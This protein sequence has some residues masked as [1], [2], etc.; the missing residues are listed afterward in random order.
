[1]SRTP[2]SPRSPRWTAIAMAAVISLLGA[3]LVTTA[4]VVGLPVGIATQAASA[5]TPSDGPSGFTLYADATVVDPGYHQMNLHAV[6]IPGGLGYGYAADLF[7]ITGGGHVLLGH[8]QGL[9]CNYLVDQSPAVGAQV[10]QVEYR[11][12]TVTNATSNQVTLTNPDY[13]FGIT[14]QHVNNGDYGVPGPFVS[15]VKANQSMHSVRTSIY[16]L[17]DPSLT[18]TNPTTGVSAPGC[19]G[20]PATCNTRIWYPITNHVYEARMQADRNGATVVLARSSAFVITGNDPT[21]ASERAGGNNP[22]ETNQNCACKADPVNT[23]TGELFEPATDFTLA[24]RG[25]TIA[26][27]RTYGSQESTVDGPFGHG[28]SFPYGMTLSTNN[29]LDPTVVTVTQE[30]GS[31]TL[32]Y[33]HG[34]TW[35]TTHRTFATLT[36]DSAT[37]QWVFTRKQSTVMRFQQSNG[38]LA[39]I[40]DANGEKATVSR[41][42]NG[43]VASI[44]DGSGR[45]ATLAYDT[46]G[47]VTT[48][49]GPTARVW[50]YSYTTAGDLASVTD[51][52]SRA[53][54]YGYD[55]QHRMTTKTSPRGG[56]TTTEYGTDNRVSAQTDELG[57]RV[58]F[59]STLDANETGTVTFTNRTGSVNVD[60]YTG[61]VLT[62]RS[63]D[64]GASAPSTWNYEYD[65]ASLTLTKTTDPNGH[66]WTYASDTYGH[67]T[68]TVDPLGNV[69]R[70]SYGDHGELVSTTDPTGI[71]TALASD[72]NG[73]PTSSTVST[74]NGLG[75]LRTTIAHANS[76]HPGDVTSVTDPAGNA[77][78]FAYDS[79]GS[80]ASV[81]SPA[82]STTTFTNDSYG[83][84]VTRVSPNGNI[85]GATASQ[86]TTTLAYDAAGRPTS[87]TDS[88]GYQSTATYNTGGDPTPVTDVA[89]RPT[90]S[91]YDASGQVT[92]STLPGPR[93][94]SSTYDAEGRPTTTTDPTGAVTTR[95]Y[96]GQGRVSTAVDAIGTAASAGSAART[97]HTVTYGYDPAGNVTT[98]TRGSHVTTLAYDAAN[99]RVSVTAPGGGVTTTAYDTAGRVTSVTD[100]NSHTTSTSYDGYGRPVNVTDANGHV[101]TTTYDS[102]SRITAVTNPAGG[103]TTYQ[104]DADSRLLSTVDPVGNT[105][106][107]TPASHQTSFAYDQDS[108]RTKV[109]DP[110][111]RVTNTAYDRRDL[112]TS[113]S[114]QAGVVT[115]TT[116][117]AYGRVT[118][119][120]APDAGTT[121]TA[122]TAAGDILQVTDQNSHVTA[123]EHDLDGR[124]TK[125]TDPAGN[126]TTWAYNGNGQPVGTV[127]GK[128]NAVPGSTAGTITRTFD[129][130]DRLTGVAYSDGTPSIGYGYDV[131]GRRT[132][133]TDGTGTSAYA[134]DP[135]GQLTS[136]SR[137]L[138][139]AVSIGY[140]YDPAG[141]VL[142]RTRGDGTTETSAYDPADRQTSLAWADRSDA[143]K[144]PS[145]TTTWTYDSNGRPTTVGYPGGASQTRQYDAASEVTNVTNKTGAAAVESSLAYTYDQRGNTSA[146]TVSRGSAVDKRSFSYDLNDRLNRACYGTNGCT[147]PIES[148]TWTYDKTGNRT[149]ETSL[150][151]TDG[152]TR[153]WAYAY[154]APGR[155][156]TR[157]ESTAAGGTVNTEK[158]TYDADGNTTAQTNTDL[159]GSNYTWDAADHLK[160][161]TDNTATV[162]FL[163]INNTYDGD[164]NRIA[165]PDGA[166]TYDPNSALPRLL[167]R[168]SQ[169]L[170]TANDGTNIGY[171]DGTPGN[172]DWN[173]N[174]P[175]GSVTD[176][177]S[178]TGTAVLSYDYSAFGGTRA[179]PGATPPAT[180]ATAPAPLGYTGGVVNTHTA[181]RH[182]DAPSGNGLVHLGARDHDPTLGQFTSPDPLGGLT[183][184]H[185][186]SLYAYANS[187]PNAYTDPS[188]LGAGTGL[189]G[190]LGSPVTTL[191]GL[192]GG[193]RTEVGYQLAAGG[194]SL[195][196]ETGSAIVSFGDGASFGAAQ[197]IADAWSPGA[198]CI[199]QQ[200][201]RR[202]GAANFLGKAA[203]VTA[204]GAGAARWAAW[205]LNTARTSALGVPYV[206]A[207]LSGTGTL[208]YTEGEAITID[209]SITG[210]VLRETL[211]HEAAHR[212]S[213]RLLGRTQ[214]VLYKHV[215][216]ARVLEEF[217]AEVFATGR[218]LASAAFATTGYIESA[219]EAARFAAEV[220]SLGGLI[221]AGSRF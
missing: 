23:A 210:P 214:S 13:S 101:T 153:T 98:T 94:V 64:T 184:T 105:S 3:L 49:T 215:V 14:E 158:Y 142:T 216:S 38:T 74:S 59:A 87:L 115:A 30:N 132:G 189:G 46:N 195:L 198:G 152:T 61:G 170:T 50:T 120:Q 190:F 55:T 33:G 182:Q 176:V 67:R 187:N 89:A 75:A 11:Y 127:T 117:D 12:G 43:R 93:T 219:A 201:D 118:T 145:R 169:R 84:R 114:P 200:A 99:R 83:R 9:P 171:D 7:N 52:T 212:A 139:T 66:A 82:G 174:D 48:V 57:H 134:Y 122:Y 88:L 80:P 220:A 135:A 19:D 149:Q 128:G 185:P 211:L 81:T 163:S 129:G 140:A 31:Q 126:I 207:D 32:F 146:Q 34:S 20:D 173:H 40:A 160:K 168:R 21:L 72:A 108:N 194:S 164:G 157:I 77:T 86:W 116:H 71:T 172:T 202:Y 29:P 143:T 204:G 183:D 110:L 199:G 65:P 62:S 141:N 175:L 36:V 44:T 10:F 45:T 180:P 121:T 186:G 181:A 68:L 221:Y 124:P 123:W 206:T 209:E 112:P 138:P 58:T 47:H 51:P 35:G 193:V 205:A 130:Y 159:S 28:W 39:S 26:M 92:A 161:S 53:W 90:T 131:D 78:T 24:G 5:T 4:G 73:N 37:A 147:S 111:G 15:T 113:V 69:A 18:V 218:P 192:Y 41:D 27:S 2:D 137:N 25:P 54:S 156:S 91:V 133:M 208:G 151:S 104:W 79:A 103:K 22:S 42:S 165:G 100:P 107:Q 196:G 203:T 6:N 106:G 167:T 213:Y 166:E 177:T 125:R 17:T 119:V 136:Y 188:G 197:Q 217:T 148:D 191:V 109:T 56:V 1:V 102:A 8:C 97:E 154:D 16:D 60:T 150:K 85:S 96:D 95:A 70:A 179:P 178:S 144:T 155:L 76:A 162:Q 63:I